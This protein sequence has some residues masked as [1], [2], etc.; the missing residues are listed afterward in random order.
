MYAIASESDPLLMLVLQS[1]LALLQLLVLAIQLKLHER[2]WTR[3]NGWHPPPPPPGGT[4]PPAG[5]PGGTAPPAAP[6]PP[7][8][9]NG[10]HSK[11]GS[12]QPPL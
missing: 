7:A 1:L 11:G 10:Q 12:G 6:P 2:G 3:K 4:A 8:G 5:P 9:P